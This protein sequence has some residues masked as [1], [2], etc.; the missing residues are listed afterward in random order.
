MNAK[1]SQHLQQLKDHTRRSEPASPHPVPAS[2]KVKHAVDAEV[3]SETP[4]EPLSDNVEE[5]DMPDA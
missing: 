2:E 4:A 5:S 1:Q 3:K